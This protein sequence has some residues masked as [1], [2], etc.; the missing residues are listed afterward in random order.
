MNLLLGPA[1]RLILSYTY[2]RSLDITVLD[3]RGSADSNSLI[4]SNLL[5][6][7]GTVFPEVLLALLLLLRLIVCDVSSVASL[8]IGVITLHNI[9]ILSLLN[10]LY[11]V[12]TFLAI[13]TGASSSNSWETD[14]DIIPLTGKT[15]IK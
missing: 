13:S 1:L 8:V 6:F 2:F 5:I 3:Q 11:F 9:I 10:H 7:N 4:K 14:I 15:S 12:N